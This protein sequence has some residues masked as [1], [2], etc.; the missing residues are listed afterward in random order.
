V[1]FKQEKDMLLF[2][3]LHPILI[4]IYADLNWYAKSRHFVD[5]TITDT[6]STLAEDKKLNRTSSSHR[7][8]RALDIRTEQADLDPFII[9][10]LVNYINSKAEYKRFHY[11]SGGGQKRLAYFHVGNAPHIHLSIHSQFGIKSE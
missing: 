5:L 6:I 4:M 2:T 9:S 11:L 8:C 1:N 7:E 3:S 10:D